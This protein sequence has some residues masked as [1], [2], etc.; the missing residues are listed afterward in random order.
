M[1]FELSACFE[2]NCGCCYK[3][4]GSPLLANP[5]PHVVWIV[6][7][8]LRLNYWIIGSY[9]LSSKYNIRVNIRII[10]STAT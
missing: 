8:L 10:H 3:I 6:I 9:K 5:F 7:R 1:E 4:F 2:T